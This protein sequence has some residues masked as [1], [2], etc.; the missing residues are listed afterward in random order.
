ML[1]TACPDPW[2]E[3][4]G[5]G[6][7]LVRTQICNRRVACLDDEVNC[8]KYYGS[9]SI[10]VSRGV[11]MAYPANRRTKGDIILSGLGGGCNPRQTKGRGEDEV[12]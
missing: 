9:V 11:S 1:Y 2:R 4:C 5:D 7:C 8:S 12:Y 6:H 10:V 3:R